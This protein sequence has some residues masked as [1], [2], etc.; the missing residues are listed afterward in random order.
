MDL[1]GIYSSYLQRNSSV[2]KYDSPTELQNT[3]R[4]K[5]ERI[6]TDCGNTARR[7]TER[8]MTER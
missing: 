6:T 1:S 5:T 7:T 4:S 3:E 8:R 2:Q